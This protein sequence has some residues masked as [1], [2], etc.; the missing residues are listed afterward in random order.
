MN[1]LQKC[2]NNVLNIIEVKLSIIFE[3]FENNTRLAS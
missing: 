3:I 1:K 2:L